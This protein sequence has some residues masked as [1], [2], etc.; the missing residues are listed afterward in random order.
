VTPRLQA[1]SELA[2]KRK[3]GNGLFSCRQAY[4]GWVRSLSGG[5]EQ[6]A[7]IPPA[8][9]RPIRRCGNERHG[10]RPREAEPVSGLEPDGSY[11]EGFGGERTYKTI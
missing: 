11:L 6:M 4:P 10:G 1:A 7:G 2:E 5:R 9:W 8:D 3:V